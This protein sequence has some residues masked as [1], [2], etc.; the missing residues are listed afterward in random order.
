MSPSPR[1]R[2]RAVP[3]GPRLE[4][5]PPLLARIYAARGIASA[6]DLDLELRR[7]VPVGAL[8]GCRRAV[9]LLISHREIDSRIV[10]VGD[11]DADGATSSAL[12]CRALRG[13]GFQHVDYLVPNRF[14]FGYGLSRALVEV[15]ARSSPGLIITVDNGISSVGGVAAAREA[16]IDVI[17]T[18]HHLPP[19]HLPEA[20]AIVNPNLESEPF[21]SKNLAGVGVA[22]YLMAALASRVLDAAGARRL[23]ADLLDLVAVGTVA[24]VVCLDRNNRILVEQGLRRIRAGHCRPGILALLQ[25]GQRDPARAVAS[26]LG[27]CVGPRLNAAGRLDDI[28][29]GIR[30]LLTDSPVEARGL[31]EALGRLNDERRVIEQEMQRKAMRA[32]DNLALDDSG[33]L[34]GVLC[35]F[36]QSWHQGV[37]GLVASRIKD[38]VHRPVVAFAADSE[39][40]LKG[41]CRSIPGLHIRDALAEVDARDPGLILRFGGHAM[42]A[43]LSLAADRLDDFR[44]SLTRVVESHLDPAALR[45]EILTDGGLQDADLTLV[46]A[47]LLR[48]AGPWGQAFPEPQFDDEFH[49]RDIRVM[50]E[51]HLRLRV[52]IAGGTR[53]VDAVAFNQA[54]RL[55]SQ[56]PDRLHLVYRLDVND[57]RG[58]RSPQLIVEHMEAR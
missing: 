12:V 52:R 1:I 4:G 55:R 53:E 36:D 34:P 47:E 49:V 54:E 58:I 48:N 42:A 17:V 56:R 18:D 8:K 14:D 10:V 29:I 3:R 32:V 22:F 6:D 41:S 21:P 20:N 38:R 46:T 44:R 2:R 57:Y 11:F 51:R 28:A 5:I 25:E 23:M 19:E 16:G 43:G 15:A 13:M 37:V 24:D 26:D 27:F 35:L 39:K 33:R 7:M 31:A 40:R 30:C 45:R 9:D 50:K